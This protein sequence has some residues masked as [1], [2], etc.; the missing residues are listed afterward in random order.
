TAAPS[1]STPAVVPAPPL[2]E[3]RLPLFD[4]EMS[5][6]E[7]NRRVLGEAQNPE[8][9]LLERLKFLSIAAHNLDEFL[10]I[11]VGEVRDIIA[12]Q[13]G[14]TAQ[15]VE[16]LD[17]IRKRVR[18]L[19]DSMYAC[20]TDEVLPELKKEGIR[21]DRVADLGKR[22]RA[23]VQDY[24][25][26]YLEPILTPLAIDPGHPFPLLANRALNLALQ[27]ESS[28]GERYFVVVKIPELSS[29]LV[30]YGEKARF[31][32]LEDVITSHIEQFLP[33]LKLRKSVVFRVIRNS[34]ISIKEEEVQDLLKSVE[35]ELRRRERR[36]VVWLE[37]EA[38]S[39]EGVLAMIL[40]KTGAMRNDVYTAP[41]PL[42]LDELMMLY[43]LEG[44]ARLKDPPFNP[45]IP[46]Q[47]ASSEDIFSIIRK[48]DVLLHRPYDSF[49]AV[50][51]F[52][53][54]A[55]EDPDVVAIKQTLYRTDPDSPVIEALRRAAER[56]KQV[57]AVV[58]LQARF[59]EQKNITWAK[60]LEEAGVQVVYGLI[61]MKTHCKVCLVVRRE[62]AVLRRYVHFST[63]NYNATTAR[64]YTDLDL[65]TCDKSI[66]AD[67]A[68]LLNVLTGFSVA[69][70][71]EL[72]E[73]KEP[74][75]TWRELV[76]APMDYHRWVLSMIE[77]EARNARDGKPARIVAKMNS[78]VDAAVIS[79]LYGAS[80]AGVKI[81]LMVRGV[82]C[83]VP[84]VP[85][86]SENIRVTSVIDRF[87]EHSRVFRFENAGAP[88]IWISSGDWMPRNFI[89]R[90]ELTFPVHSDVIKRRIEEQ[91]LP[92]SLA[93]NVKGWTLDTEGKYH[94]RVPDGKAVRSQ[95]AFIAIAR[96]EAVA[97]GPYEEILHRAGSFRRKAKKKKK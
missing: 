35:T 14:P 51:D 91:I 84:G 95:E 74:A 37:V 48:G 18:H 39:D 63:G 50:I 97:I 21:I 17:V 23:A 61:G 43:E 22:D 72:L 12:A 47:L 65:M 45:R 85:T 49:V 56:G 41:G 34:D 77:R 70:V 13:A 46:A 75:V 83:L 55:A 32:L 20:L 42:K 57:T 15:H 76:V 71:Q 93:D 28:R 11:R 59:D 68:Q 53:Q 24:F 90:I 87:L 3:V 2:A 40:A 86:L 4:R 25:N 80:S 92:I 38:G 89:R 33:G 52:V 58:E 30:F 54:S 94:R 27:L 6:I 64:I 5:W 62:G 69:G 78:V 8:V 44:H 1:E 66:A 26:T 96:L 29:R 10:M 88:E 31:V 82:C 81:D 73:Q 67:A 36:E 19:L 60:H 9:P 79:A 16:K 7:F